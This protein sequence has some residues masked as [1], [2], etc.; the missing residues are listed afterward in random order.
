VHAVVSGAATP[1]GAVEQL[2]QRDPRA[3]A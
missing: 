2:L 3:E 1:R